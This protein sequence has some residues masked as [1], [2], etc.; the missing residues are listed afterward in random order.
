MNGSRTFGPD[1]G[2]ATK[3][4]I[5]ASPTQGLVGLLG[6]AGAE[7]FEG[8]DIKVKERNK[9]KRDV[10]KIESHL[11]RADLAKEQAQATT[12]LAD[13]Q[14]EAARAAAATSKIEKDEITKGMKAKK[15]ATEELAANVKIE[16]DM[17][18][19][20]KDALGKGK[21][22][23]DQ[24]PATLKKQG[25][26]EVLARFNYTI[27]DKG[28]LAYIGPRGKALKKDSEGYKKVIAARDRYNTAFS[29]YLNYTK[30][31]KGSLSYTDANNAALA[32]AEAAKA[33]Q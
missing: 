13:T 23:A 31:M 19:M 2:R 10:A 8:Q 14:Q 24:N 15:L 16:K 6:L 4:V 1:F 27:D 17:I 29:R 32:A 7:A 28:K 3:A 21:A 26:E 25:L 5:G 11:R 20:Y 30:Q 18:S 22:V 9:L 12:N 33:A